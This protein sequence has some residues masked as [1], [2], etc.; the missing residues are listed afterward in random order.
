MQTLA[1]MMSPKMVVILL[2]TACTQLNEPG[3]AYSKRAWLAIDTLES[4]SPSNW[5]KLDTKN[6]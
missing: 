2:L 4:E 5:I 6:V 1:N 3:N